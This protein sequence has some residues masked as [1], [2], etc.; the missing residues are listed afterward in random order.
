M[1]FLLVFSLLTSLSFTSK[2]QSL[3]GKIECAKSVLK[4][5]AFSRCSLTIWPVEE[6]FEKSLIELKGK[7]IGGIFYVQ[8][9]TQI[10]RSPNNVDA[11]VSDL[12]VVA[13]NA[14]EIQDFY[15]LELN[16]REIPVEIKIK[17]VQKTQKVK[18]FNIFKLMA[19]EDHFLRW[20]V[21]A[22][23]VLLLTLFVI[24]YYVKKKIGLK[25]VKK[26]T[27]NIKRL[28]EKAKKRE[29]F[30]KL[31]RYKETFVEQFQQESELTNFLR[32]IDELQYQRT[33]SEHDQGEINSM[34]EKILAN[35]EAWK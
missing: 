30:E 14:V 12:D 11:L 5:G 23:V 6:S 29:D 34:K 10:R 21:V 32:K 2:A 24:S 27:V 19:L 16:G 1:S 9:L 22:I 15:M 4:A 25:S 18:E 17:E 28:L 31:Y 3:R 7:K 13:L 26:N 35:K 20:V 33:W 8:N